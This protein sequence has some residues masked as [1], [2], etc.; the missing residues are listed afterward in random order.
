MSRP[1]LM[2]GKW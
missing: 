1:T 2:C